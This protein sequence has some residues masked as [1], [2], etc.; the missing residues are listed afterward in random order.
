MGENSNVTNGMTPRIIG[1]SG[2]KGQ[3][4]DFHSQSIKCIVDLAATDSTP[5]GMGTI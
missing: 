5:E 4:D 2:T 3:I 1:K